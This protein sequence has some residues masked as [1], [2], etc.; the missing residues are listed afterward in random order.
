MWPNGK[1]HALS[2]VSKYV[3]LKKRRIPV[4]LLP[5]DLDHTQSRP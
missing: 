5:F 4:Q 2:R 3:T 1:L